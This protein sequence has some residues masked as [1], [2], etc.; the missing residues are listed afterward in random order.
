MSIKRDAE[1]MTLWLNTVVV[2]YCE[3]FALRVNADPVARKF[4][5]PVRDGPVYSKPFTVAEIIK[6][7]KLSRTELK[8]HSVQ[9]EPKVESS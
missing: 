3:L 6:W 4:V 8:Y 9:N 5:R 1:E 7:Q 2:I